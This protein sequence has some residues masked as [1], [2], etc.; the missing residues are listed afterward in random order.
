MRAESL[1]SA[2]QCG[3]SQRCGETDADS[4]AC[5]AVLWHVAV[6]RAQ[7]GERPWSI[8]ARCHLIVLLLVCGAAVAGCG[9]PE[10]PASSGATAKP[11]PASA[12]KV[13]WATLAFPGT[14]DADKDVPVVISLTNASDTPWPDKAT[15]NPQLKDGSY[16]VRL[17]HAWVR[18]DDTQQ[19]GRP[20]AVRTDLPRPLLPGESIEIPVTIRTPAKPGE[21]RLTIELVQELVQWFAD[22]GAERLTLPVHVV[23]AGTA[24]P[25]TTPSR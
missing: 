16:A 12:L 6:V 4:L 19:G 17:T 3:D 9:G 25:D 18:A 8:R 1:A 13:R 7:S 15:A 20:G 23:P 11:L 24:P 22:G 10:E 2:T 5:P 14:V 21:Y